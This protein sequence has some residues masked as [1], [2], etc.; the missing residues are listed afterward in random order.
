M[1]KQRT[2][3]ISDTAAVYQYLLEHLEKYY[4]PVKA[5]DGNIFYPQWL[6]DAAIEGWLKLKKYHPSSHGLV[7]II[8]TGKVKLNHNLNR[9]A[10]RNNYG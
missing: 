3:S 4:D 6:I 7:Y 9:P 8:S 10:I 1:S 5:K 2:T